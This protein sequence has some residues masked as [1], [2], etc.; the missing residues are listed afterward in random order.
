MIIIISALFFWYMHVFI[1]PSETPFGERERL[2]VN[3]VV[4]YSELD[5]NTSSVRRL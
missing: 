5:D 3:T 2:D 4:T 1:L